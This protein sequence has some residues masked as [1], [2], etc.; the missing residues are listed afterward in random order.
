M[1]KT[2]HIP[3]IIADIQ[4]AVEYDPNALESLTTL[5]AQIREQARKLTG[6]RDISIRLGKIPAPAEPVQGVTM[7]MVET[8]PLAIS[9]FMKRK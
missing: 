3:V 2:R 8:D 5:N 1:T 7:P 9:G 6:Y 4:V